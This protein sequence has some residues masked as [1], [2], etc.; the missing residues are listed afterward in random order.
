MTK[1]MLFIVHEASRSGAPVL[2]LTFLK[3]MVRNG[4]G[5]PDVLLLMDGPLRH[6]FSAVAKTL[7]ADEISGR[8]TLAGRARTVLQRLTRDDWIDIACRKIRTHDYSVVYGNSIVCMPWLDRLKTPSV[9]CVCAVH[10]L[11]FSIERYFAREV[12]VKTLPR[13]DAIVAG[14]EAVRDTLVDAYSVPPERITVI[15]AFIDTDLAI[16]TE[17]AELRRQLGIDADTLLIGGVGVPELRKGNDLLIPLAQQL[18]RRH[19]ALK[20]KLVWLGGS[21][22]DSMVIILGHDAQKLGLDDKLMFLPNSDHPNDYINL[23]DIFILPSREDPFPLVAVTAAYLGKPIVAFEKSGG[24]AELLHEG[25]GSL[26][27]YLDIEA[28]AASIHRLSQDPAAVQAMGSKAK[29][30]VSRRHTVD[31]RADELA[32]VV[33][34]GP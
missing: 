30:R 12:V 11:R 16:R 22:Q 23:Y 28:F 32:R 1:R 26:V 31:A 8:L 10:E 24:M 25:A 29:D 13:L 15:H 18:T 27:P 21:A 20:F 2:A 3:W 34:G 33:I 14:S 9:R 7:V 6:E 19:P 17:K 5:A 4:R